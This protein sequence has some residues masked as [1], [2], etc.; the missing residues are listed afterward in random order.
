MVATVAIFS[1]ITHWNDFMGPLIY[2]ED[3]NL[4]PLA[5]G[6]QSFQGAY[7]T[8]WHW[9]MAASTTMVVPVII[10]LRRRTRVS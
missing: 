2:L 3:M 10:L 5:L 7:T 9:L 8:E 4:R 6:L 1:F